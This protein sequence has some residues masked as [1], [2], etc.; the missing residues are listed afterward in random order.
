MVFEGSGLGLAISKAY[1]EMLG[2][3]I[4]V[5]SAENNG[6][7]FVF[8]IPYIIRKIKNEVENLVENIETDSKKNGNLNLLIVEDDEVSSEFLKST[9]NGMF[10]EIIVV[11]NG[12]D[13]VET[14]R[15]NPELDLVLMDIKIPI[16]N[17]YDAT[18]E[19]RKFNK[20]LLIIAQTAYALHGD[21]EKA[22]ESGCNDYITKP[23]DKE[24]LL[25]IINKLLN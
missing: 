12:K 16:M 9:L 17:G 20:D 3:I 23:I 7:K 1:V 15:D 21:K 19:I 24:L 2:G 5:E 25:E 14:C 6:S 11:D 4:S 8:T 10:K 18:K 22:I 13:A